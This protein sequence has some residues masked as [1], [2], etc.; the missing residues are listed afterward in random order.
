[1]ILQ[2]ATDA[3]EREVML[4]LHAQAQMMDFRSSTRRQRRTV[5]EMLDYIIDSSAQTGITGNKARFDEGL[6]FPELCSVFMI[7]AIGVQ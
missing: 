1:M 3:E 5:R 6:S 2:P 4:L 7:V